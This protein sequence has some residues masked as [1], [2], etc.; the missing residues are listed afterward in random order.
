ML[1]LEDAMFGTRKIAARRAGSRSAQN[2]SASAKLT[3]AYR[4][5]WLEFQ[6]TEVGVTVRRA[7]FAVVIH[8]KLSL[9]RPYLT[10]FAS[11]EEARAAAHQYIDRELA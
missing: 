9:Q 7:R 11:L 2:A 3:N 6:R 1:P 5:W 8:R 4:G 10:G